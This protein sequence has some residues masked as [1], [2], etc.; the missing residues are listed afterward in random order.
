MRKGA[1]EWNK[2]ETS[3]VGVF[4]NGTETNKIIMFYVFIL[5]ID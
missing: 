2:T 3:A 1:L 5:Y 4:R